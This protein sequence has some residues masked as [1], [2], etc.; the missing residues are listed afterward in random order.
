MTLTIDRNIQKELSKKAE[1]AKEKYRANRVSII[2]MNPKTGAIVSMVN[3]PSFDANEFTDVY[4]VELVSYAVYPNP[5]LDL[6]GF[7]LFVIDSASGSFVANVDGKR[8]KLREAS[9]DEIDNYAIMKYKFKNGFGDGNYKND[10]IASLYEPGS[11]F[12]AFSVAIGIDT[13]EITPDDTYYDRG[14]VELDVGGSKPIRISNATKAC[15]G[16]HT[17]LH[18]LNWSCNVGMI[19]IVEKIGRSLFAQYLVDFGFNNKT[20]LTTDGEVYAQIDPYEKWPRAKF[21]NMSF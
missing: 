2:V 10:V 4:D 11:V 3:S 14:Y 5:A 21:F 19:N 18:S 16:T 15:I 6:F 8:L 7:P 1:E 12:K 17:Y 9:M 13:G 20:N